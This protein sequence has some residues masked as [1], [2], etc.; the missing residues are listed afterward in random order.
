VWLA[1]SPPR[2]ALPGGPI[3]Y[4]LRIDP[5]LSLLALPGVAVL[6]RTQ[7][8]QALWLA[9][10]LVFLLAWG[11]KWPHYLL[12]LSAPLCL[13]AAEGAQRVASAVRARL[14]KARG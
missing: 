5:W 8:V 9:L 6:W 13:A 12:L 4:P 7:R 11:T 10:G 2:E 3:V 14:A 1:T